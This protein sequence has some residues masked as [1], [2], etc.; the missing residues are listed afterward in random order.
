MYK[1]VILLFISRRIGEGAEL[2][3]EKRLG[4]MR[5]LCLKIGLF[6]A[7]LGL[8]WPTFGVRAEPV[9]VFVSIVPQK[10]FVHKIGGD[11]IKV[12]V[13]VKPGASP[14]TYEPRPN[15]MVA[16]SEARIYCAIGVP[17][18]RAWLKKITA[19]NP[20][21]LVVHTEKGIKKRPMKAH[22]HEDG[23]HE[24]FEKGRGGPAD[25]HQRIMDPHIWLSPPLVKIQ[26]RNILNAFLSVDATNGNIYKSNYNKFIME[27]DALD[28]HIR[29]IFAGK[30]ESAAFMAFHPAWGYFA[31]TYG[32][33]QI[34]VEMEGK[35][36]KPADLKDL[37]QDARAR[38]IKVIFVQPE[39][40][41]RSANA[42][43][44]AIGGEVVLANP[45][46]P[47]W[48]DNLKEMASKI[49]AALK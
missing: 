43:A 18:E 5:C 28:A 48:A 11:L 29:G 8:F 9:P 42:I 35:E 20:K 44:T 17:F 49:R 30:G 46:A 22:H 19:A 27:L 45:L 7:V 2:R 24:T 32:L 25:D 26:A 31:Q 3:S 1:D 12:M 39:F 38:G 34:A 41:T 36:P 47:D 33:E 13:M 37:I 40:S 4:L 23:N 16:L 14:A 15:Q 6:I 10:Y 21:M